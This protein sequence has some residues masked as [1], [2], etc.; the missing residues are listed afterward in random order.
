M[1]TTTTESTLG[2]A[3]DWKG[4]MTAQLAAHDISRYAFVRAC[5]ARSIC[6]AHTA[7]CLLAAPHTITGQRMPSLQTAID[8]ARLAGFDL[9]LVP[10]RAPEVGEWHP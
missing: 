10:R 2:H 8:M 4:A 9:V 3:T 6:A 5:E 7:E 1:S